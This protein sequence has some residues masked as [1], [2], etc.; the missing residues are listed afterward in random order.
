GI[1][2][3]LIKEKPAATLVYGDTN[4]T[5]AGSLTSAHLCI[6][7]AHIE[8]GLRSFKMDMPEE[9]NRVASDRISTFLFCP[10]KTAVINL[11]KEGITKNVWMVGDI[12]YDI[13]LQA[14]KYLNNTKILD[15]YKVS[16]K[17]YLLLTIHRKEIT[18]NPK[19]LIKI[20]DAIGHSKEKTIFLIHPRT[21]K[22]LKKIKQFDFEKYNNLIV[23]KPVGYIDML[24][25]EK[26]AKKIITDS[27][28]VQKESFWFKVP[29]IVLRKETEWKELLS[30]KGFN[31]VGTD[32]DQLQDSIKSIPKSYKSN[33]NIFGHGNTSSLI[34]KKIIK[35][36]CNTLSIKHC[37]NEYWNDT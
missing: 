36:L 24:I 11:K 26:N 15:T 28:G 32:I 14:Q 16:S 4:S 19:N 33:S 20:I 5:L 37:Q 35:W 18:N 29:C 34:L 1:E 9:I 10:T 3:I 30:W 6:P 25:L 22:I 23:S 7:V 8:A 17:N 2:K 12:M 27:G 21:E 13:F 31:L